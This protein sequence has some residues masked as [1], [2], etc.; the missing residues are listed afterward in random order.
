MR[1]VNTRNVH[2]ALRHEREWVAPHDC[3]LLVF[4]G[5]KDRE[6]LMFS[7][8]FRQNDDLVWQ[9]QEKSKS[10]RAKQKGIS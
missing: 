9:A 4:D 6:L 3:F 1:T 7:G 2:L 10:P 8:R 5:N